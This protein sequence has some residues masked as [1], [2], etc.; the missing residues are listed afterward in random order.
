MNRFVPDTSQMSRILWVDRSSMLACIESGVAGKDL[1]DA[2]AEKGLTMG[3]EPDSLE[4]S[5]LGGWVATRSSGM[6]QQTYGNI[7]QMISKVTLVTSVGI[8]EKN[9][10]APRASVGPGEL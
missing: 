9:Y 1:E 10:L 7:E 3:H 5:T 4:F 2:L 8:L 6:K